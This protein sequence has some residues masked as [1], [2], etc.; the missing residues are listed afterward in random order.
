M[1]LLCGFFAALV[2]QAATPVKRPQPGHKAVQKRIKKAQKKN[3]KAH[4][5]AKRKAQP[6][7][8]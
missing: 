6:H 5:A 2:V 3:A 1:L 8:A 4:K 7:K